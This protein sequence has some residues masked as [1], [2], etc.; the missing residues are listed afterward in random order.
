MADRRR[1]RQPNASQEVLSEG[2]SQHPEGLALSESENGS[3]KSYIDLSEYESTDDEYE[4]ENREEYSSTAEEEPTSGG[5]EES[6][7]SLEDHDVQD[8]LEEAD[9]SENKW[10]TKRESGDGKS[11]NDQEAK[12]KSNNKVLKISDDPIEDEDSPY[13]IPTKGNFYQHDMRSENERQRQSGRNARFQPDTGRW[14]HDKYN[15]EEQTS[16][17]T[18]ELINE[19]GFDI[20]AHEYGAPW[21]KGGYRGQQNRRRGAPRRDHPHR[22][23]RP[24]YSHVRERPQ[25]QEWP[26]LNDE[27]VPRKPRSKAQSQSTSS[28]RTIRSQNFHARRNHQRPNDNHKYDPIATRQEEDEKSRKTP[29][30]DQAAAKEK[31]QNSQAHSDMNNVLDVINSREN[32]RKPPTKRR[33]K[34]YSNQR[35]GNRFE[36]KLSDGMRS[37]TLTGSKEGAN[38][39]RY[40]SLRQRPADSPVDI[41]RIP[42]EWAKPSLENTVQMKPQQTKSGIQGPAANISNMAS[43]GTPN[44]SPLPE[45][46]ANYGKISSVS[47]PAVAPDLTVNDALTTSKLGASAANENVTVPNMQWYEATLAYQQAIISQSLLNQHPPP[48]LMPQQPPLGAPIPTNDQVGLSNVLLNEEQ[49]VTSPPQ[50]P[51]ISQYNQDLGNVGSLVFPPPLPHNFP[52]ANFMQ[53]NTLAEPPGL[54]PSMQLPFPPTV[55]LMGQEVGG[56]TYYPNPLQ[57]VPNMVQVNTPVGSP[58]HRINAAIPIKQPME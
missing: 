27:N 53:R 20:R 1:R 31:S 18:E 15:E 32:S 7:H 23:N 40:S 10:D 42:L 14:L 55:E 47:E 36:G 22:S 45:N 41:P 38:P 4:S 25:D 30:T 33:E 12:S 56:V 9:Q 48:H 54:P 28:D 58:M 24:A 3:Q 44:V 43:S 52:P 11:D 5:K 2:E 6:V 29:F 49:K 16:K 13:F 35:H 17:C 8:K 37:L 46:K 50:L 51:P 26:T 21:S 34:G 39:R 19:Y 57:P